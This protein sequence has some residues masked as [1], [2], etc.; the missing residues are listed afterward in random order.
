MRI[1]CAAPECGSTAAHS[2]NYCR[3]QWTGFTSRNADDPAASH[4]AQEQRSWNLTWIR[5]MM[6]FQSLLPEVTQTVTVIT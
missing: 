5:L 3:P 4:M 2:L 6:W 1:K